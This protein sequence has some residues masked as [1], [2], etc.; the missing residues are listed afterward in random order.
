MFLLLG[1]LSSTLLVVELSGGS[2]E[3]VVSG[4]AI[5]IFFGTFSTNSTE[6]KFSDEAPSSS[7]TLIAT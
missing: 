5:T 7:F 6:I 4:T 1:F 2:V 3:L